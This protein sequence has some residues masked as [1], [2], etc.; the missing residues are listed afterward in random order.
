MT[1]ELILWRRLDQPGHEAAR[2]IFHEP[3]WHL[4]GTAVFAHQGQPCRLEYLVACSSGWQTLHAKIAGWVG[5]TCVRVDLTADANQRW[6][7]NGRECPS[8]NG[9]I[10][11][12]LAFSPATNMLPIRRLGLSVGEAAEVTA[13]WLRFPEL[14]L[15]PLSQVYRHVA[16]HRYR[17]EAFGG[18]F[19]AELDVSDAGMVL[20]YPELWEAVPGG[21]T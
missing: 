4:S 6:R 17:Y 18:T 11:L 5:K 20:R 2:V 13:A 9:C 14:T 8:V 16:H 7:I 1:E 21:T 10:D 3:F 19:T 12:D 15:Q